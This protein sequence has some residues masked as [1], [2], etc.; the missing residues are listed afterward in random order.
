M[1][2]GYL[3]AFIIQYVTVH[4][5][6]TIFAC[7]VNFFFGLYQMLMSYVEDI[8]S[9]F[10]IFYEPPAEANKHSIDVKKKLSEFIEFHSQIKQLSNI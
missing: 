1:P 2:F 10:M 8:K 3:I 4:T 9:E 5:M 6:A 7:Y